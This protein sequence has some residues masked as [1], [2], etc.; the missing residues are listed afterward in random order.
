[1]KL[2]RQKQQN[3][4]LGCWFIRIDPDKENFDIARVVNETFR[5]IK[6]SNKKN[7]I[8]KLLG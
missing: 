2:K 6:Q 3:K 7:L 8:N 1:M 4:K 5:H